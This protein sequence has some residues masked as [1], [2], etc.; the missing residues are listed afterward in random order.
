[1][2][3]NFSS[4][5]SKFSRLVLEPSRL[6]SYSNLKKG[7]EYESFEYE[8]RLDT[9]LHLT[10]ETA[11]CTGGHRI[12]DKE[13]RQWKSVRSWESESM[14]CVFSQNTPT[15]GFYTWLA[16]C[17]P[18]CGP[19]NPLAGQPADWSHSAQPI[20]KYPNFQKKNCAKGAAKGFCSRSWDKWGK[21]G[22]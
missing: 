15:W 9:A 10:G 1:M 8:S 12:G 18:L 19:I 3:L 17:G 14:T 11:V 21:F 13:Q 2:I 4:L 6:D 16:G 5:N 20:E 7:L 22:F